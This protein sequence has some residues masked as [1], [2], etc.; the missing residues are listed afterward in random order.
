MDKQIVAVCKSGTKWAKKN[1]HLLEIPKKRAANPHQIHQITWFKLRLFRALL[2]RAIKELHFD[3]SYHWYDI[4]GSINVTADIIRSSS[5]S[6]VQ[7]CKWQ[8]PI[9]NFKRLKSLN[10]W[11]Q[12]GG[13]ITPVDRTLIKFAA[14]NVRYKND[15]KLPLEFKEFIDDWTDRQSAVRND[16]Q[17]VA[18][19]KRRCLTLNKQF[20]TLYALKWFNGRLKQI[21]K[22]TFKIHIN[23]LSCYF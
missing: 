19:V 7:S 18:L 5:D 20:F 22:S 1:R 12:F 17:S 11:I 10:H 15:I 21:S 13:R 16:C 2:S 8:A 14:F 9:Q 6:V 4:N 3:T 23:R